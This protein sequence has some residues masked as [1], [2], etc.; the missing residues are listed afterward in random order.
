M[1]VEFFSDG[2]DLSLQQAEVLANVRKRFPEIEVVEYAYDSPEALDRG[3]IM[4]PGLV[5]DGVIL[6]LGKVL[7]AGQLRRFVEQRL[8]SDR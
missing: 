5:A 7:S 3:I 8:P 4:A 6:A 1:K 2:G